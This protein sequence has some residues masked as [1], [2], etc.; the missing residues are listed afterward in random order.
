M[1]Y[2]AIFNRPLI[3]SNLV[4]ISLDPNIKQQID[5]ATVGPMPLHYAARCGSLDAASC[6]LANYGNISF[7]D[8]KGWAPIHH[9]C[10]FDNVSIIKLLI[11]KQQ[12]LLELATRSESRQ[13]PILVA[14][15]AGSLEAV[16]CLIKLGA[17]ISYHDEYSYNLIHLA[18]HHSHKN[19]I[20]YFIEN[21]YPQLHTWNLLINMLTSDRDFDKESAVKCLE[22]LTHNNKKF[23]KD[24]LNA[25]GIEKLCA[26]LKSFTTLTS[27]ENKETR[28]REASAVKHQ[29]EKAIFKS[30]LK[31]VDKN[32]ILLNTLSVLCNLSDQVEIKTSLGEVP[33]ITTILI[34][35]LRTS[36]NEDVQSRCAIL[37]ADIA[38]I[39][40]S[41]RTD[42]AN[43][44][45]LDNLLSLLD[46]DV[47]DLLVNCVNA[48]EILCKN[49][50]KNQDHCCEKN[51][52]LN[53][54]A[55]LQ[56]NSGKSSNLFDFDV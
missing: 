18:T 17:N 47:E 22:L 36:N 23:W 42:F 26:I 54:I 10:Y 56:L 52:L 20:E 32:I 37:I 29:I 4:M 38:S 9:A 27:T 40:E 45:C 39:S 53:C 5:Y 19:V 25:N 8:N 34:Q 46:S 31:P 30:N 2:A 49:N 44:G 16:K 28:P 41:N 3:I 24:I 50:K 6:L 55:L 12:E 21:K 13:T 7:A 51:V 35:L 11:R 14:A 15:S 48:I 1:H 43:Q 33:Q